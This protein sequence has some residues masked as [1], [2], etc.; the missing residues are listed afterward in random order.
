MD[1]FH[2]LIDLVDKNAE[3]IPEGDYVD[4]CNT[5]KE[6]RERVKPPSFLLD[7]TVPMWRT[8]YD[9]VSD[10]PPVYEPTVPIT[11][12]Q[13]P[14]WFEDES[15]EMSYPGLN[16]FL[17][18]LHAEWAATDNAILPV[19]WPRHIERHDDPVEPGA[20]Y[21]PPRQGMHQHVEDGTTV[22]EVTLTSGSDT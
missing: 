19:N 20:Y 14:E 16:A 11:A 15:E 18:G 12:G 13:P 17:Q 10:G 22:V 8:D 9:P 2:K 6:L 3:R 5:I 21:P 7:Q 4:I 1:L